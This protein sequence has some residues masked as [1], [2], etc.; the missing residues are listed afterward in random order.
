[1]FK[2]GQGYSIDCDV[3]MAP[4]CIPGRRCE[5]MPQKDVNV[6]LRSNC[7]NG[8]KSVILHRN[9]YPCSSSESN[10]SCPLCYSWKDIKLEK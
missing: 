3:F 1:L 10:V 2:I 7:T 5:C 8:K 4:P 6:R 9:F